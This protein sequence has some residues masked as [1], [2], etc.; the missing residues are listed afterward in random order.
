M[1]F[2]TKGQKTIFFLKLCVNCLISS[3][4]LYPQYNTPLILGFHVA[5]V[6]PTEHAIELIY[7]A[8]MPKTFL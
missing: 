8:K 4:V 3:L 7:I 6:K 2:K 1:S 5:P